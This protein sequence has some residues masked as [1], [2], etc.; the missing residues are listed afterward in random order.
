MAFSINGSTPPAYARPSAPHSQGLIYPDSTAFDGLG[1]PVGAVGG[2]TAIMGRSSIS[3]AGF[4]WWM[5]FF[6]STPTALYVAIAGLTVYDV[7]SE[8]EATFTSG[9]MLRP[10]WNKE[11]SNPGVWYKDFRVTFVSL[12]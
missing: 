11:R 9:Y 1:R 6:S 5:D 8:A 7:L 10:T 3:A 12:E 2:V 4:T